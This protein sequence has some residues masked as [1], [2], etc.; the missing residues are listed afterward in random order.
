VTP[1]KR[2]ELMTLRRELISTLKSIESALNLPPD[3]RALRSR[4]DRNRRN[5][6]ILNKQTTE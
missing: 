1:A 4:V 2:N 6:V 5:R 3:K